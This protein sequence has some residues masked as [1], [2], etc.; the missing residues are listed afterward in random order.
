MAAL[1]EP[2]ADWPD[3]T[4][5]WRAT[6]PQDEKSF[7]EARWEEGSLIAFTWTHKCRVDPD[8]GRAIET[9]FIE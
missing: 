9:T 8:T 4:A 3:G 2:V 5:I 1:S 6:L 7:T